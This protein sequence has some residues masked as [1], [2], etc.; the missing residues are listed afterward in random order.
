MIFPIGAVIEFISRWI[1][2]NPGDIIATGTCE[3]IGLTS[4]RMLAARRCDR[5]DD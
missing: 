4:G 3:G 2:W 1:T 5:S